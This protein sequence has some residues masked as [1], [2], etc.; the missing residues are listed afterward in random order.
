MT[1]W[2]KDVSTALG[3]A[4]AQVYDFCLGSVIIHFRFM[5]ASAAYLEEEYLKQV[6]D[7]QSAL[8][9]GEITCRIDQKRTQTM[10]MQLG[11]DGVFVGS[12]IFKGENPAQRARAMVAACTHYNDPATVARVAPAG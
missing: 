1:K 4:I 3:G 6:D 11:A 8:Y 7:K 2:A 9:Q 10:T 12:G 5:G